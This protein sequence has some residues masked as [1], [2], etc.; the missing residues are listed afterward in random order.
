M[1]GGGGERRRLRLLPPGKH[2]VLP[3]DYLGSGSARLSGKRRQG[4]GRSGSASFWG[5]PCLCVDLSRVSLSTAV[6]CLMSRAPEVHPARLRRARGACQPRERKCDATGSQPRVRRRSRSLVHRE[7]TTVCIRAG[8][9]H[10]EGEAQRQRERV[11][12]CWVVTH[13]EH[14]ECSLQP[15]PPGY[16]AWLAERGMVCG[17]LAE[18]AS[19]SDALFAA[20]ATWT[21]TSIISFHLKSAFIRCSLPCARQRSTSSSARSMLVVPH[22]FAWTASF[23][24]CHK[25]QVQ[26]QTLLRLT[27]LR[28]R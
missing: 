13:L 24:R 23:H 5:V 22:T 4:K 11:L 7:L 6:D 21:A 3:V 9:F 19:R 25:S 15:S 28:W 16:V 2:G 12:L 26:S 18:T 17:D 8:P 27:R 1:S 14:L 10:S 20:N